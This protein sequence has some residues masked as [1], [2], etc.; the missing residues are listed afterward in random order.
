MEKIEQVNDGAE[1]NT[2]TN[3]NTI[4]MENL[5]AEILVS[6]L[7]LSLKFFI[8][9]FGPNFHPFKFPRADSP[10]TRLFHMAGIGLD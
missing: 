3:F 6:S 8:L 9:F 5:P 1:Q 10:G 7:E 4:K 2:T